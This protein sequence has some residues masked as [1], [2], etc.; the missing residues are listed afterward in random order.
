MTIYVVI[1]PLVGTFVFCIT[2]WIDRSLSTGFVFAPI[3]FIRVFLVALPFGYVL[4]FIP[5]FISGLW[6]ASKRRDQTKRWYLAVW[7]AVLITLIWGLVMTASFPR[8]DVDFLKFFIEAFFV[9]PLLSSGICWWIIKRW[10]H[11]D[12]SLSDPRSSF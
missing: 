5:A 8:H 1:G 12:S 6:I 9:S 3:G 11:H 2:Q 4:A 7:K 10:S